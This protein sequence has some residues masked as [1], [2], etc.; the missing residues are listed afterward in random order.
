MYV[1][2]L[3][4]IWG[5]VFLAGLALSAVVLGVTLL[6][7]RKRATGRRHDWVVFGAVSGTALVGA[8]LFLHSRPKVIDLPNSVDFRG[9]V[10]SGFGYGISLGVAALIG[11]LVT[12]ISS[13]LKKKAALGRSVPPPLPRNIPILP[14]SGS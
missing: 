4:G 2:I 13:R 12:W 6:I 5:V 10:W 9:L 7:V 8:L 3:F 11:G 14:N 1:L